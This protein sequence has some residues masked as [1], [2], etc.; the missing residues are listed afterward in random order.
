MYGACRRDELSKVGLHHIQYLENPSG[1]KVTIPTTKT[2]IIRQFVIDH[3]DD[4][5]INL[6]Q[7]FN[8]YAKL[9]PKGVPDTRFF[10][11]YRDCKCTKQPIGLHTIAK[12]PQRIASFLRL[13]NPNDYTGHCF[14]RSSASF[15]AKS[16]VDESI[17]KKHGG[18]TSDEVAE[19]YVES[20]VKNK[21]KIAGQILGTKYVKIN[22]EDT[23]S[24]GNSCD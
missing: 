4:P 15:L 19:G 17:L 10:M 16:G 22:D 5:D 7:I 2:N 20:S 13:E 8:K 11:C 6:I 14:R 1:I 9:R 3:G 12:Y 21:R 18:W 23:S 24:T